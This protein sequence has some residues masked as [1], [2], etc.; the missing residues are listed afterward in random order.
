MIRV[1]DERKP[2]ELSTASIYGN[3]KQQ[4]PVCGLAD[5]VPKG[6][7]SVCVCVQEEGMLGEPPHLCC[8]DARGP[9]RQTLVGW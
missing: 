9:W 3:V 1:M 7:S 5:C 8:P 2:D 4:D 6:T